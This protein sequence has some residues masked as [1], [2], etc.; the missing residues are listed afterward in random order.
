MVRYPRSDAGAKRRAAALADRLRTAGLQVDDPS[1]VRRRVAHPKLEYFFDGD[2]NAASAIAAY[3]GPPY[4]SETLG[5]LNRS[6]PAILPGTVEIQI[7]TVR[8]RRRRPSE[9]SEDASE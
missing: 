1:P 5:K 7:P 9:E 8:P 6:G 4:G 2:R 3:L